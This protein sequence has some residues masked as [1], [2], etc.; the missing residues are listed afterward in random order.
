M[1][2]LK[3]PAR[4]NGDV[5]HVYARH[6]RQDDKSVMTDLFVFDAGSGQRVEIMLGVQYMRVA[7][8][9][10]SMMLARMTKDE[11]VL[12][13]KAPAPASA[14]AAA[15]QAVAKTTL[16]AN[17]SPKP[18]EKVKARKTPKQEKKPAA[19]KVSKPPSGW[20]DITEEVRNL[21]AAVSGVDASELELDVEMA[22]FG[23]DSLIG[24]ELGKE[25]ES[26]FKCTLDQNEQM[27]ATR[28]RKLVHCVSNALSGPNAGPAEEESDASSSDAAS[29][30]DDA[31]AESSDTGILTPTVDEEQPL[32]LKAVVLVSLRKKLHATSGLP[33]DQPHIYVNYAFGD[34]RPEVWW[35]KENLPKLSFLKK[36]WDY[37]GVFG[38]ETPIP[39][40]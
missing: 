16:E 34:K 5:W 32:P 10:M 2:S 9:S 1:R 30:S 26:A 33:A 20:R 28:L 37:K 31:G 14:P 39:R 8:A 27:E 17:S 23:I 29:E 13:T 21:V 25:V 18:A 4:E 36:K 19:E 22:D 38:K 11:S 6:S 15:S 3:A 12:R 35:S 40:F 24:M 7:K